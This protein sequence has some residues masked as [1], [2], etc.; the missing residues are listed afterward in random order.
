LA[1]AIAAAAQRAFAVIDR[2]PKLALAGSPQR[3][4]SS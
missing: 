4:G 3:F 1:I 2:D